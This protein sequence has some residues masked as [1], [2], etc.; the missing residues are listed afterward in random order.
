MIRQ[1]ME[2]A[3]ARDIDSSIKLD[4]VKEW[5]DNIVNIKAQVKRRDFFRR[6]RS[7][8]RMSSRRDIH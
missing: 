7:S 8:P 3:D 6:T 2:Y 5:F 1:D 4:Y